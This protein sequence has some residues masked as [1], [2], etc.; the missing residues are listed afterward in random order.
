MIHTD[1]FDKQNRYIKFAP[2]LCQYISIKFF[3]KEYGGKLFEG[4]VPPR[5]HHFIRYSSRQIPS[6]YISVAA[7]L[8]TYR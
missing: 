8:P 1:F 7:S 2:K 6:R 3:E 4:K 5:R